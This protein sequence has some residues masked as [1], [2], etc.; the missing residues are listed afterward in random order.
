MATPKLKAKQISALATEQSFDKGQRYY[1]NGAITNPVRQGST[2][3][4]DCYGSTVYYPRA[5]LSSQGVESSSCT[6]PYDWGG[7]CKHQVALLLTY[8]DE[9]DRFQ[10]I[11]PL[12]KLLAKRSRDD[13]LQI[14]EE[15]VQRHP[16]LIS[17]VDAPQP[18]AAGQLPDLAK[19]QRQVERVFKGNEMRSM[20]AGLEALANNGD[21][22]R[23]SQD[24]LHAGA[25]YQL[26]LEAANTHYDYS[27]LDVDYD[28]EVGCVI[29]DIAEGL[30]HCL[31]NAENLD[32]AQRRRW[33]ETLLN[34]VLK[35]IEL[36][37]MDYAYPA[38]E[39]IAELTTEA[40]W[41]WLEP[42]IRAEIETAGRQRFSSWGKE[43]LVN[44]LTAGASHRETAQ[45]KDEIILELGTPEQ[46]AFFHLE[47]RNFEAAIAI[48]EANFKTWPGLVTQFANGLLEAGVPDLALQFVQACAQE[49]RYGYQDWLADFYQNHGTKEQFIEAQLELLKTRFSVS[50][51]QALQAEAEPLGKWKSLRQHLH[52]AL[53]E[54][55]SYRSLME[56]ALWEQDWKSAQRYL[57][58]L[59]SYIRESFQERLADQIKTDGP[60]AAIALYRGLIEAAIAQRGRDNYQKAARHLKTIQS[61]CKQ[62]KQEDEFQQYWQ[63]LRTEHKN[64]PALMDELNRAGF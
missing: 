4:A 62:L 44:L 61:L 5:T 10:V 39:A 8:L 7:I 29:Q 34:A 60:E 1:R 48:A 40:D 11:Q 38:S 19:Y 17:V 2:L 16:D 53:T 41:D 12:N 63:T 20:A 49:E 21:R 42:Q 52:K 25:V 28:G 51:Y 24:W 56:I 50:R 43:Q 22:L 47:K 30:S 45:S 33:L 55:E 32:A 31:E 9:P 26:L 18:P 3:W 23:D 27:V 6:C 59:P 37:G 13:L 35:D 64:L 36:G 54:Q 15:M 57:K 14:I 46:Q 58:K